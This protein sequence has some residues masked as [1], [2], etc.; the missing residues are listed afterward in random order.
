LNNQVIAVDRKKY[1]AGLFWQPVAAGFVAHNY[2]RNLSRNVDGKLNLYT[3]Y[4]SMVGLGARRLGHRRG[5]RAA[6]AEVMDSMTEYT[7]FLAVFRAGN[8]FYL[9]AAR[10]GIILED[11][12]IYT[13]AAARA[14]YLRLVEMPDWSALFAPA[15]W[16]MP[17]AVDRALSDVIGGRSSAVLRPIGRFWMTLYP[18]VIMLVFLGLLGWLFRGPIAQMI[19][20]P[21]RVSTI[22]PELA[23]EYH[24][25]IAEKDKELDAEFNI[26]KPAPPAPLRLPYDYLPDVYARAATCYQAMA[27]LMQP[28]TGWN[29]TTVECGE[30]YA[31]VQFRRTFGSI[32]EFY[33][34][35]DG[36]MPG[37]FVTEQNEDALT[38]RARLPDVE[39]HA[40][41]DERDADTIVRDVTTL[42]QSMSA[43]VDINIVSDTVSNGVDSA[44][45]DIVEIAAA[46]KLVP[47]QF[48]E[49]FD[50]FGGVFMP[51]CTWDAASRTWN[52]E[53][54]IYAK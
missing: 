51:K 27:F 3:E 2:A 23:A 34:V 48:M 26:V 14:E 28:V 4:R 53:V 19:S 22:N 32:G 31:A 8:A 12:L 43:D 13:D 52:Y 9:V 24:R 39:I 38:V 50:D 45:F 7:S 30:D 40:S 41:R 20:P 10:N 49:I 54:I 47:M 29:Q 37:G 18:V 11:K 1:A 17:R 5:M 16:G 46:S 25:Q 33:N 35:A 42:F 21:P 6:A 36:L 44:T 15:A